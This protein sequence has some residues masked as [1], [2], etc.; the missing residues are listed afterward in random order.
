MVAGV[1]WLVGGV[2]GALASLSARKGESLR[3]RRRGRNLVLGERGLDA[4][5]VGGW[6]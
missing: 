1:L 2:R 3:G 5:E 4:V 6:D